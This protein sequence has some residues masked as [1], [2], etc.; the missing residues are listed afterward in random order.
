MQ[1]VHETTHAYWSSQTL[2]HSRAANVPHSQ[3]L[4]RRRCCSV[5]SPHMSSRADKNLK[6]YCTK[7]VK[8]RGVLC[9]RVVFLELQYFATFRHTVTSFLFNVAPFWPSLSLP[10]T[11]VHIF[12][13]L[14]RYL[15]NIDVSLHHWSVRR[16]APYCPVMSRTFKH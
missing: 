1:E 15:G 9:V 16:A 3:S 6:T 14:S 8:L 5:V 2:L 13:S 7:W 10:L 11:W 4:P 12:V